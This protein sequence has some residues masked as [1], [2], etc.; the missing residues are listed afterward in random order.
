MFRI[1]LLGLGLYYGINAEAL[2]LYA[3]AIIGAY[4]DSL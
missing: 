1:V 3:V 4:L 2:Y